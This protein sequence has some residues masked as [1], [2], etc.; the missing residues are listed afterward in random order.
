MGLIRAPSGSD[1]DEAHAVL[2]RDGAASCFGID[3]DDAPGSHLNHCAV[4]VPMPRSLDNHVDLF[5]S[6]LDFVM[7]HA[8]LICRQVKPVDTEGLSTD[9]TAHKSYDASRPGALNFLDVDHRV[10]Q[11]G[12]TYRRSSFAVGKTAFPKA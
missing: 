1:R 3:P 11:G 12:Q 6:G 5:L 2:T 4:D 10:A 8:R 9:F 7:F